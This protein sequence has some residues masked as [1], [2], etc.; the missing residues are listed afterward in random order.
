VLPLDPIWAEL[1]LIPLAIP[2]PSN[3][4]SWL[5]GWPRVVCFV[6]CG[7][8][9]V[10]VHGW[11]SPMFRLSL[12]SFDLWMCTSFAE[13]ETHSNGR[14]LGIGQVMVWTSHIDF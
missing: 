4:M 2:A 12:G 1:R 8:L 6:G 10:L 5:V 13:L 14:V 3:G 11:V 7:W 9:V